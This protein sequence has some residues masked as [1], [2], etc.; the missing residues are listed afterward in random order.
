MRLAEGQR[1]GA[2][3]H[4]PIEAP[5]GRSL[6]AWSDLQL[7][8]DASSP[9]ALPL[10]SLNTLDSLLDR[11]RQREEDGFPRKIR[12]GRMMKPGRNG[13]D[14]VVVVPSTVEEKFFHDRIKIQE[15]GEGEGEAEGGVG[16]GEE[17]ELPLVVVGETNDLEVINIDVLD[18]EPFL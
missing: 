9:H 6:Y 3:A 7:Q 12:I 15:E 16:S 18:L 14:K 11:D 8:L 10:S 2:G 1:E 5:R 17:E 13:G 4:L